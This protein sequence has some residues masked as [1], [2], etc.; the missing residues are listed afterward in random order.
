MNDSHTEGSQNLVE[1]MIHAYLHSQLSGIPGEKSS[2]H[3]SRLSLALSELSQNLDHKFVQMQKLND[4]AIHLNSGYFLDET[5]NRLYDSFRNSIPYDRVSFAV[6]EEDGRILRAYWERSEANHVYLTAGFKAPMAGSSL[7]QILESETPRIIN[8]L[9][10][11][12][13]EHPNS[14]STR[15][16][17]QQ[18]IRS[19]L[20]CPIVV[21]SQPIGFI[22]FSSFVAY[23][24]R[25]THINLLEQIGNQLAS[26]IEKGKT[27]EGVLAAKCELHRDNE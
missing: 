25:D 12:L 3:R 15:L 9:K 6:L 19:S 7:Q 24:Y 11:Y 14:K 13:Q 1:K 21:Q 5:L 27:Y 10:K 2:D 18:G 16:I 4:D 22:F 8:C 23:A 20:T 17:Y 26:L